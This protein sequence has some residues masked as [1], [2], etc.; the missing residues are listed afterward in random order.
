[1]KAADHQ[2]FALAVSHVPALSDC[3]HKSGKSCFCVSVSEPVCECVR[4]LT[5]ADALDCWST[6]VFVHD[7]LKSL[8][9]H[10][11]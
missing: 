7:Q 3:S 2:Q 6:C 11:N 5:C 8:A 1:M 4:T 9:S 10:S